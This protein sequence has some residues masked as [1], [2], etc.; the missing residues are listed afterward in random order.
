MTVNLCTREMFENVYHWVSTWRKGME[1][2]V[3]EFMHEESAWKC[4]WMSL[5]LR[6]IHWDVYEFLYEESAWNCI[7]MSP[8]MRK[9]HWDVCE[10]LHEESPWNC[11]W[12]SPN[13]RKMYGDVC[14]WVSAWE[15]NVWGRR[16]VRY[17]DE[18]R[19]LTLCI[20]CYKCQVMGGTQA[21]LSWKI[22]AFC[23]VSPPILWHFYLN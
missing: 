15:Q 3:S 17:M 10:F 12:M 21:D 4:I 7:W 16:V 18:S 9:I 6:K 22:I 11:I 19:Q 5:C 2:Y 20:Q 8:Y 14:E 13:M 23:P 1:M